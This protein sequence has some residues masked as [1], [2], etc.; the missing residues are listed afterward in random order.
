VTS[1][2]GLILVWELDERFGL[3]KLIGE[4]L[5]DSRAGRNRQFPLAIFS[6]SPFTAGWRVM[7]PAR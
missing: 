1:D 5:V 4:Y 6:V 3:S 2:G 7:F